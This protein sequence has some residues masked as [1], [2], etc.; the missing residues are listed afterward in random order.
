MKSSHLLLLLLLTCLFSCEH[1]PVKIVKEKQPVIIDIQPFED[2]PVAYL[3][4]IYSQLKS[5]YPEIEIKNAI[6][7]PASSLN[8]FK[9]RHRADSLIIYLS[10]RTPEGH[11]TLGLTTLDISTVKG[12][13]SDYGV[14]GLGFCPGKACIASSFRLKKG[15]KIN[16][17]FKI[18][19]HELGHTQ[20]LQHCPE[21]TCFMRD[22]E[23]KNPTD[24]EIEFC[25]DCKAKLVKAGWK[26]K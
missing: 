23:G 6:P 16:Q 26:L 15:R 8:A 7:F 17:L 11:V 5:I 10:K 18:A 14:M 2:L 25:K 9:T 24:E 13:I 1:K 19:I 21:K 12:K 4:S 3:D 22:A 20:G